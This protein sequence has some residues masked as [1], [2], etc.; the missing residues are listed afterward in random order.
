M[1][2]DPKEKPLSDPTY[3]IADF[4]AQLLGGGLRWFGTFLFLAS[5]AFLGY[6]MT[7]S[8]VPE[9]DF[10]IHLKGRIV[11]WLVGIIAAIWLV[12]AIVNWKRWLRRKAKPQ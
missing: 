9:I 2:S 12:L 5:L 7:A 1:S 10:P 6:L 8:D 3:D 11:L 4:S